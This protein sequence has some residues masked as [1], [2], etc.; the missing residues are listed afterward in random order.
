MLRLNLLNRSTDLL[1]RIF[2][3]DMYVKFL[4]LGS[5]SRTAEETCVLYLLLWNF[6]LKEAVRN[7]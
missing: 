7:G 4:S 2:Y 6:K 3:G 5:S 1:R